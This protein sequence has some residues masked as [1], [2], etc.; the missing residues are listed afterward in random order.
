MRIL[1]NSTSLWFSS[2]NTTFSQLSFQV[3]LIVDTILPHLESS[4]SEIIDT[5]KQYL[6]TNS[7]N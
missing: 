6:K 1:S 7:N 5:T 3:I 2:G 4:Q